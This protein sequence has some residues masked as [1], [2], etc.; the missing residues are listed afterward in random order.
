MPQELA[1]YARLAA[2]A[3][4]AASDAIDQKEARRHRARAYEYVALIQAM[5][6]KKGLAGH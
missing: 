4:T 2:E 6:K 5:E 3:F 1:Q